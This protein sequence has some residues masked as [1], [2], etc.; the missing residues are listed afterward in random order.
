MILRDLDDV[1][2]IFA[3]LRGSLVGVGMTAFSR[4]MPA[5]FVD[6]YHI[7]NLRKTCDLPLLRKKTDIFCLEE[8]IGGPVREKNFNSARVLAHPIVKRFLKNLP[9]PTGLLLYQNYPELEDLAR[10]EGWVLLA[11][12]ADLRI[13]VNKKAF[14]R[15]L[16]AEL[17]LPTIPGGIHPINVIRDRGYGYWAG[18]LGSSIVVQLPD[19][20]QGGGKGTFFIHSPSEY[21]LLRE[22]LEEDTWRSVPLKQVSINKFIQGTPVS[23]AL[24]LTRHGVLISELQRQ[25]IDLPYCN[26][27]YEN[28]VF[29]GHVWDS[30]WPPVVVDKARS[31]A[32][33]IGEHLASLGYKG[34]LGIDFMLDMKNQQV[35]ALE[36]NPRL[37]GAFPMI[38][39]LH[40]KDHLIPMEVFQILEFLGLPYEVDIES[41]NA[42]YAKPLSG[43]HILIFLLSGPNTISKHGAQ[44]GLYEHDY[45]T[46]KISF[47]REATDYKDIENQSQFIIVDGPPGPGL[48]ESGTADPLYRL[49]RL[50]FS[51]PVVNEHGDLS[52]Y[53]LFAANWAH[54]KITGHMAS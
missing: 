52:P 9:A 46:D 47:V 27:L 13:R 16:L 12:P 22:Q 8:E 29:C 14:F 45:E 18:T 54:S 49:C 23:M 33:M 43:S 39:Q 41:L 35:Y 28:G 1:R 26:N 17:H 36:I 34:I 40:V 30:P 48:E 25:L 5:S 7:I 10:Q 6:S 44:P 38:S 19:I 53:A 37:T 24:C 3:S 2:E 50:L 42:Q 11:N 15:K 51:C 20:T 4:I 31:Q 21:C 32:L